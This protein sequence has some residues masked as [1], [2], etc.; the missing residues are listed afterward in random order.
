YNFPSHAYHEEKLP[1]THVSIHVGSA[2]LNQPGSLI[3]GGYDRGR[4]LSEPISYEDA[5]V[6]NNTSVNLH[7]VKGKFLGGYDDPRDK[8]ET[9]GEGVKF[10]PN[11]RV[12]LDAGTP[13]MALPNEVCDDFAKMLPVT[14]D[15]KLGLYLWDTEDKDLPRLLSS[16]YLEFQFSPSEKMIRVPLRLLFLTLDKPL[17]DKPTPYFPCKRTGSITKIETPRMT[18]G[19]AF[20]QA[21]NVGINNYEVIFWISQAPGPVKMEKDIVAVAQQ[22]VHRLLYREDL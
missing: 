9:F 7:H 19:R 6:F 5:Q 11:V 8:D 15:E 3:F 13:Y 21:V 17:K 12:L 16:G 10:D 2:A 20:L 18:L 14:L 1:G 4:Q 22:E